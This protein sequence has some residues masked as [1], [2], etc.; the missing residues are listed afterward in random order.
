MKRNVIKKG[1]VEIVTVA[2]DQ[3]GITNCPSMVIYAKFLILLAVKENAFGG[4]KT[5]VTFR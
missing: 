1:M 4:V 2:E 3:E 5:G